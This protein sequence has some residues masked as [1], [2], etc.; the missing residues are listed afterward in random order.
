MFSRW[1]GFRKGLQQYKNWWGE[2]KTSSAPASAPTSP[3]NFDYTTAQGIWNLNS[4]VQFSKKKSLPISFVGYA[5]AVH[6]NG[7]S[8]SISLSS[9]TGGIATSPSA[10]DIVIVSYGASSYNT[11]YPTSS[12]SVS[13]SGY[14]DIFSNMLSTIG[15]SSFAHIGN[16]AYKVMPASPDTSVTISAVTGGTTSYMAGVGQAWVFRS[17]GTFSIGDNTVTDTST[18]LTPASQ[19]INSIPNSIVMGFLFGG[20]GAGS[21]AIWSSSSFDTF[22][23]RGS[24]DTRDFSLGVGYKVSPVSYSSFTPSFSLITSDSASYTHSIALVELISQ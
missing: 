12:R 2:L 21:S 7:T 17:A 11:E 4:T 14:T 1:G 19:T 24:N 10:G 9:L 13:T 15:T 23:S 5:S 22:Y 16:V 3:T 6:A 20:H 18:S 8:F